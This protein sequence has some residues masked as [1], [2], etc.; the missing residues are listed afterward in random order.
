MCI[1][2]AVIITRIDPLYNFMIYGE[3]S[4]FLCCLQPGIGLC[5][6]DEE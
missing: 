4:L 2:N 1:D 3:L 6:L 5:W